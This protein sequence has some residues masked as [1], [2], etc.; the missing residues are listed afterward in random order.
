MTTLTISS[1]QVSYGAFTLGPIDVTIGPGVTAVLGPNGSGKTTLLRAVNRPIP[2]A[3]G[4]ATADGVDLMHRQS[5]HMRD[6]V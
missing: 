6:W 2:Q 1:L 3:T 4:S 5:R